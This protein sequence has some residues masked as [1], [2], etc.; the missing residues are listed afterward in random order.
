MNTDFFKSAS[1]N[2]GKIFSVEENGGMKTVLW[3]MGLW[4]AL[5]I[6]RN[7]D[8][9]QTSGHPQYFHHNQLIH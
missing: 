1:E 8:R 7:G 3:S 2:G 5:V 6:R 4:E 9:K